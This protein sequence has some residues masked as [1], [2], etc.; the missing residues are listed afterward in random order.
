MLA[1]ISPREFQCEE[2]SFSVL[3]QNCP[4]RLRLPCNRERADSIAPEPRGRI[5]NIDIA[6]RQNEAREIAV[7]VA[8]QVELG[9]GVSTGVAERLSFLR[10]LDGLSRV[11]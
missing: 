2:I 11:F 3:L 6:C 1:S 8:N 10:S 9:G 4:G 7:R 5:S